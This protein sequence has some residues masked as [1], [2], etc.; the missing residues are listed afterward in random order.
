MNHLNNKGI[1]HISIISGD[2]QRNA[3]FY[4]KSLGLR[5][6]LKTVNQDDP[7]SY[8]LFYANGSG[9]PGSRITFFPWPM[10]VAAKTGT[11]EVSAI[12]F[13]V[14]EDS[15]GY[16][17][18]RFGSLDIDFDGPS[19][20]FGKPVLRFKDPD[21]L[22]LELVE[23]S[24]SDELPAW[25]KS[26][27]PEEHAIRGFWGSSLNLT[28]TESTARILQE[29]L[30]FEQSSV[31]ENMILFETQS[32]LG[33]SIILGK[34]DQKK[35]GKTGRGT[36]HHI[37]FRTKDEQEL[38]FKREQVLNMGLN[39]TEIID[40]HVFKSVYF[41]TP[42]G[43]L[44]ELATDGPGYKSVVEDESEMGQNLFLPSWLEPKREFI[45][46]RLPPVSV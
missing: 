12:S 21:G 14:P 18:E 28:E 26:P 8:H 3:D 25:E 35:Q 5:M 45:E 29:L 10:A 4:V 23:D 1:H 42:G 41:H 16:W 11:G 27:V 22:Q 24:R 36:V 38:A 44:F 33:H 32:P 15:F 34:S 9:Q 46:K 2:A 19:E 40:R 37:A 20:R 7:G 31:H 6:V 30:G 43:V 39:P 17:A 13:S